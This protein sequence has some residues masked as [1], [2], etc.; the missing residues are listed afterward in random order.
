MTNY[1]VNV[2]FSWNFSDSFFT[3]NDGFCPL[4]SIV[5][6]KVTICINQIILIAI[7]YFCEAMNSFTFS[8]SF[9][10]ALFPKNFNRLSIGAKVVSLLPS[11]FSFK[12]TG[13]INAME[14]FNGAGG[15]IRTHER[16]RDR[17]LR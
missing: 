17:V 6:A 16:L 15:G 2:F 9:K 11:L 13:K 10:S 7:V 12:I 1:F 3:H 4:D 14:S 8:G 5:S